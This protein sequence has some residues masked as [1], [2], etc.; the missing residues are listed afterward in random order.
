M[1]KG[2]LEGSVEE[3][4]CLGLSCPHTHRVLTQFGPFSVH[5]SPLG[6]KTGSTSTRLWLCDIEH[7][8]GI[9]EDLCPHCLS[10]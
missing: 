7:D 8:K 6:I 2:L 3:R 1:A 9:K 5:N 4:G 10:G